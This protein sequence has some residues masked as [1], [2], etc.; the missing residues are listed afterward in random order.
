MFIGH[1]GVAMAAK[2]IAPKTSLGTLFMAAQFVDLLWPLFLLLGLEHVRIDPGNTV[3]TPLDF[4]HYPITHSLVGALGWAV[5]FGLVLYLIRKEV[6][7]AFIAGAL[8]FS[9]WLLDL[10]VH[11]PDLPLAP[12]SATYLG[13]GLWNSLGGTLLIE[14]ALLGGGAFVYFK[15]TRASNR[16][17]SIAGWALIVFLAV[18]YLGNVFGPPPPGEQA[19]AVV[20][21]ATWLLVLWGYWVDRNR[22]F[23]SKSTLH[24]GGSPD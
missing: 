2:K 1:F 19:I 20:G 21:N 11:R 18:V 22:T 15:N 4:H 17:G 5:L 7:P 9:H 16:V 23:Q 14:F 12:G 24:S 8:V 10:I 13:L 6:R 3:V